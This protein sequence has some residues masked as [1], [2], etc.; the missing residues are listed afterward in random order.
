[1]ARKRSVT[2][3]KSPVRTPSASLPLLIRGE[4]LGEVSSK[5][6]SGGGEKAYPLSARQARARLQQPAIALHEAAIHLPRLARGNRVVFEIRLL[7]NFL[8]GSHFPKALLGMLRASV[9]GSREVRGVSIDPRSRKEATAVTKTV[10]VAVRDEALAQLE[11][12]LRGTPDDQD[13]V[14]VDLKRLDWLGISPREY[15]IRAQP[16]DSRPTSGASQ[17][18]EALLHPLPDEPPDAPLERWSAW[19]DEHGGR[20]IEDSSRQLDT[21]TFV[22]CEIPPGRLEEVAAFNPLRCL[23]PLATWRPVVALGGADPRGQVRTAELP[24]VIEPEYGFRIAVFDGGVDNSCPFV[25]SYL[26]R[27][28]DLT[29][30]TPPRADDVLHGHMVTTTALYGSAGTPSDT[31][32]PPAA[33]DA[34]RVLPP[35]TGSMQERTLNWVADRIA[36]VVRRERYPL[37]NLSLGP[38]EACDEFVEPHYWTSL[39]D[40]VALDSNTLFIVASGND[41]HLDPLTNL[42]RVQTPADG[43]NVLGVGAHGDRRRPRRRST[44]S[45]CGPGRPGNRLQ[46]NVVAFGGQEPD[47]PFVGIGPHG[48]LLGTQGTSFAAPLVTHALARL[49][50]RLT[51]LGPVGPERLRAFAVHFAARQRAHNYLDMGYGAF[52]EDVDALLTSPPESVTVLYEDVLRRDRMTVYRVPIPAGLAP[53][54]RLTL[55][56]TLCFTSPVNPRHPA[57]YTAAACHTTFRPHRHMYEFRDKTTGKITVV[58]VRDRKK[59]V[60][61]EKTAKQSQAPESWPSTRVYLTEQELRQH[62]KWE[63]VLQYR[64]PR[65]RADEADRPVLEVAYLARDGGIL[66]DDVSALQFSMLLTVES[67]DGIPLHGKIRSQFQPLVPIDSPV[68]IAT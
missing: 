35:P 41:G 32:R 28:I 17:R 52:Q 23:R 46:P 14:W 25:P 38:S 40:Q 37:V 29:S 65:I 47:T 24:R 53:D 1:M 67:V 58:D 55:R 3:S 49:H 20:I 13:P 5:W 66:S 6:R 22:A 31:R 4:M 56:W 15:V 60:R 27:E 30:G 42:Q 50:G 8:A 68:L 10:I 18:W 33:V 45:S 34:Y 9:L 11:A 62:G 44:Y 19:L 61:L 51:H 59:V 16:A 12:V 39:F 63:T 64:I 48:R 7:A 43:A 2:E 26:V 54:T 57:E 36:E 21:L